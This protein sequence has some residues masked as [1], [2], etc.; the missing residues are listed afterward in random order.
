MSA[1]N[2][3][4]IVSLSKRRGFVF[5]AS[6]IYGGLGSA[7]DYGPLGVEL[8]NNIKKSWWENLV[9]KRDD[10]E[11]LDSAIIQNRLVWKYS[12]HEDTFSDPL[13]DCRDCKS[14]LRQ[15][16]L[17]QDPVDGRYLCSNCGSKNLTEPRP[18][19][20]M[21][22]T[23][24][25]AVSV[26][27][28]P[29]ALAYLRPE[30]AQGIF[31]NFANVLNTSRRKLPFGIAQIGKAFRN[32]V[33]PGNFIFRTRE[34]E[35]MELE[36]FCRPEDAERIH[37]EWIEW[38]QNWITELG[39]SNNNLR[40]YEQSKEE[41]A[42]YA[43]RT[44]DI[45]YRFFP[46]RDDETRQ[47]DELMGIANRTD[48]DLRVH[49]KKSVDAEGKRLNP[50]STEDLSYFDPQTN[51]RF[52]PYIIEPSAG[53]NRT[54][55]AVMMDAY[56]ERT[57]EKGETRVILRLKSDLA[58][59]KA[60][61]LPLAKN[62]PEIVEMAM[63]IKRDLQTSLRAVY[64]DTGGIGKLYARQDEIGTPF[65]VTVD[66]QSLED[67]AVT[68]RDRDTWMQERINASQLKNY[69]KEKLSL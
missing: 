56:S 28:D 8:A 60:A 39:I 9:Y 40:L 53:V 4:T 6:E 34:F 3:E 26:E 46:E 18:F 32:E 33:T 5:P 51:E 59:I 2:I 23:T 29:S 66:H 41:L 63:R 68:V 31:I 61:V 65:C 58:P 62:K 43:A 30:T 52:Y 48:Y 42:H 20:L 12:G 22:R 16:K 35:Q 36:Y 69:L 55:L 25:G 57:N 1:P 50:D 13:V 24:I 37:Q 44:V 7:W 19:N 45:L 47:F 38:F 27:D 21:F 64:D 15:D 11:G 14:R 54:L 49:S 17:E 67:E 10:I